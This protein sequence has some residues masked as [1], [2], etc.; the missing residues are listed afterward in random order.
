M[1]DSGCGLPKLNTDGA[2]HGGLG[3]TTV[4]PEALLLHDESGHGLV[5]SLPAF[6]APP[7]VEL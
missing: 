1:A 2:Y 7:L 5:S 4:G 3:H 6:L